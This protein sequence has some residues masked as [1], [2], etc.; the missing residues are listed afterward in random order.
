M[1]IKSGHYH[2]INVYTRNLAYLGNDNS[3]EPLRGMYLRGIIN[4]QVN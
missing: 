4:E 1:P 3:D 2:I